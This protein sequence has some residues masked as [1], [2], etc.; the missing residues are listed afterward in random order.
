M[1]LGVDRNNYD[2]TSL[3]ETD[4]SKNKHFNSNTAVIF[5]GTQTSESGSLKYLKPDVNDKGQKKDSGEVQGD[6][7]KGSL[8]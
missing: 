7:K 8:A 1:W 5:C 4:W 6:Y 2:P 3:A